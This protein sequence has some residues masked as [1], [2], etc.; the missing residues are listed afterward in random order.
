ME[1]KSNEATPQRPEGDRTLNAPLVEMNVVDFIQ[2]VK[3][4]PTWQESERNSI[5]IFKSDAMTIV[6]I[7]LH[8]QAELKPHKAN[9][10]ISV[11]VLEG[12]ITFA[13][14]YERAEIEKGQMIALQPNIT[15]S[16][17]ATT[18]SFFLLTLVPDRI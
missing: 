16:V 1:N 4:E 6:L 8:A 2:K 10:T 15:H 14:E 5:T 3:E 9:G 17:V 12:K 13:T 11:Q 7:G 18:E